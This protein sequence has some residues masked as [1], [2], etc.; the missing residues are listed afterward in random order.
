MEVFVGVEEGS[1]FEGGSEDDL[2]WGGR[3]GVGVSGAGGGSD[4]G[5]SEGGGGSRGPSHPSCRPRM[6]SFQVCLP[7]I[8]SPCTPSHS[9]VP[10][11]WRNWFTK[12]SSGGTSTSAFSPLFLL[13]FLIFSAKPALTSPSLL[14]SMTSQSSAPATSIGFTYSWKCSL[15][16]LNPSPGG[17]ESKIVIL[18]GIVLTGR[19]S[20]A[21]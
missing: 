16:T 7:R 1:R 19:V 10:V 12:S 2:S 13:N 4:G 18:R 20:C 5:A 11:F 9:L 21:R 14:P 17:A 6:Y 3:V 15:A 8:R